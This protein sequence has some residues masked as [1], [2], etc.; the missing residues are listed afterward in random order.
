MS[1][2]GGGRRER[3]RQRSEGP[4][5][6]CPPGQRGGQ[7]RPLGDGEIEAI[8]RTALRLLAELGMG[9]T[10]VRLERGSFAPRGPPG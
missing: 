8:Y 5:N 2:R 7:Y 6:P 1:R 10:P 3:L 9:E 4:S